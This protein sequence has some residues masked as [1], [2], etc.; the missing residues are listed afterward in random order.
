MI[1]LASPYSHPSKWTRERRFRSAC[2]QAAAMM[3]RGALVFSPIA[4]SH[5]V[6]EFGLPRDWSFWEKYDREMI[7][8]CERMVVL[9]LDGWRD[10]VGVRAEIEIAKAARK[11]VSYAKPVGRK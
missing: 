1:Y 3:R 7:S 5:P 9:M 2:R 10:S 8:K 4:H 6:A 11:P